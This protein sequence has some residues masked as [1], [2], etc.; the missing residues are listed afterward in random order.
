MDLKDLIVSEAGRLEE[1]IR[2]YRRAIHQQPEPGYEEFET[3][4]LVAEILEALGIRVRTGIA[5]TGV[6][7]VIEGKGPGR[8]VA[9]RADMDALRKEE[10]VPE[11]DRPH[12]SKRAGV[13]HACG[14]DG[15]IAI[16]L[17]TAEILHHLRD[18]FS[19]TVTLLFQ[20]AE[21]GGGGGARMV[22]EGVLQDPEVG[23]IFA[24][25]AWP[26]LPCG[27]VGVQYGT[28]LAASTDFVIEVRGRSGHAAFPHQCVDPVPAAA[29]IITSLQ[30]IRS[31]EVSPLVGS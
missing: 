21:E 25:H 26:E 8:G 27:T 3:A 20:P 16:L 28:S 15:H 4:G 17:G 12:R 6:V 13:M 18:K 29:Q 22:E 9:L 1:K 10:G 5:R 11:A 30:T 14:H 24:L 31:R 2:G 19:G 7:G 23:A